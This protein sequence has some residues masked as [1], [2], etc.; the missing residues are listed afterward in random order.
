M[1]TCWEAFQ[2]NWLSPNAQ[3][4]VTIKLADGT[5]KD[6]NL[7]NLH[8]Q[9]IACP[10]G[11][12]G[13]GDEEFCIS[14]NTNEVTNVEAGGKCYEDGSELFIPDSITQD[15]YIIDVLSTSSYSNPIYPGLYHIGLFQDQ[16]T[17]KY[18]KSGGSRV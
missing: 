12:I 6:C 17:Q 3:T 18:Y 11:F 13:K 16:H 9:S 14:I 4:N 2:N 7:N 5:V 15:E 10:S 1:E 8:E